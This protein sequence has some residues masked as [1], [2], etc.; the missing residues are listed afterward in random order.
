MTMLVEGLRTVARNLYIWTVLPLRRSHRLR[1]IVG[2][3]LLLLV[4]F[5]AASWVMDAF[6]PNET[7]LKPK[8][9]ELPP[10][11]PITR[12]SFVAAP[13]VVANNAIRTTLD[14]AAPR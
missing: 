9:A 6:W 8:L 11:Q 4:S 7:A 1:Y 13:I 2:G 10:L 3:V 12:T 14:N 5:A